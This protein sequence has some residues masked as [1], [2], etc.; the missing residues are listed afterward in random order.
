M[1][2][3]HLWNKFKFVI[4]LQQKVPRE[5]PTN[6]N[7]LFYSNEIPSEPDGNQFIEAINV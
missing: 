6:K 4:L 2:S 1:P 7:V 5:E 3:L